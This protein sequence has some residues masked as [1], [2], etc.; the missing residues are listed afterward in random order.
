MHERGVSVGRWRYEG[1][2]DGGRQ[3]EVLP[4][5]ETMKVPYFL[6]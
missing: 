4:G 1:R 2:Q 5:A 3:D 6:A